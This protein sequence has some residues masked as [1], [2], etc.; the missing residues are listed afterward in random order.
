MDFPLRQHHVADAAGLTAVH[1]SKVL[2]EFRRNGLNRHQRSF[3][4]D[5]Q[6]GGVPARRDHAVTHPATN[7]IK[8]SEDD[9]GS[10]E[11]AFRALGYKLG[12]RSPSA[13]HALFQIE[14]RT[15]RN[16]GLPTDRVST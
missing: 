14:Y 2:S 9:F 13:A 10:R 5:P 7:K 1:M 16:T 6:A 8:G 3:S 11:R 15:I 12:Y 4:D